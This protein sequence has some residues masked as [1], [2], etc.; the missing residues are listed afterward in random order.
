[1]DPL[2]TYFKKILVYN[3]KSYFITRKIGY[4]TN[5]NKDCFNVPLYSLTNPFIFVFI[6]M[7]TLK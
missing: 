6:F 1:M 7:L 4:R 5:V 3:V 2:F